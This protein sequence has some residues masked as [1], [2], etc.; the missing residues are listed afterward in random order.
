MKIYL[1]K[2]KGFCSGVKRSIRLAEKAL[3]ER[4]GP[5]FILNE[6]VHNRTII[7]DLKQRGL[8]SVRDPN[9]IETG[10]M[11]ISAH[12]IPY[13]VITNAKARGLDVIDTSCPLVYRI[14]KAARELIDDGY[15]VILYGD[16]DHDE[17]AGIKAI[18]PD[19]IHVL[20]SIDDIDDL[21]MWDK[22]A[23]FI[24]QSTRTI[25]GFEEA[26]NKLH[27]KYKL[28]KVVNTIC[29][30]TR[31]RQEAIHELAKQVEMVI[32][33]GSKTS[34][35]SNR[36]EEL[37]SSYSIK[38]HL[39]DNEDEL[40]LDW[41]EGIDNLGITS[42]ASTPDFLVNEVVKRI[43]TWSKNKNIPT[44]IAQL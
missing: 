9:R 29:R 13:H 20:D 28:L 10:T 25:E 15:K 23:A 7:N 2:H 43:E 31:L 33:I 32:V 26:A 44:E 8:N 21:P 16:P 30:A 4:T 35:N 24:S 3:D 22:P 17:I 41:L 38:T 5:I 1:A 14:H 19:D 6:I 34:A 39:I 36:L 11:I 42:G 27:I 12:S 18:G 40:D 37:A